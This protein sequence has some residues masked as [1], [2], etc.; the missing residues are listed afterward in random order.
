MK[1]LFVRAFVRAS[2]GVL[3][4]VLMPYAVKGVEHATVAAKAGVKKAGH[5]YQKHRDAA[6][7]AR[8]AWR[9]TANHYEPYD[10]QTGEV[11]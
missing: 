5:A 7:A 11:K 4:M 2:A 9:E 3:A 10:G 1:E 6:R 8:T